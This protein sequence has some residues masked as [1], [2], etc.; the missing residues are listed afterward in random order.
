MPGRPHLILTARGLG[1]VARGLV[2]CTPLLLAG[3]GGPPEISA[4]PAAD[5]ATCTTL[6]EALPERLADLD[7]VAYEPADAPGGAWGD[8]AIT[9]SCG[10]Q[11]PAEFGPASSCI[12]ADGVDWFGPDDQVDGTGDVDLTSVTLV[13]HVTLHVPKTYRGG[14]LA[15]A[16]TDLAAPLKATLTPDSKCL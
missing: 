7:P 13:P 1:R 14:T 9:L 3:C 12:D 5:L 6:A 16:L 2:V 4:P 11:P 15:A 8:P 10:T